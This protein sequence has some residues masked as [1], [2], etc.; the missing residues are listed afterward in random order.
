ME[1]D[2][3]CDYFHIVFRPGQSPAFA[4]IHPAELIDNFVELPKILGVRVDLVGDRLNSFSDFRQWQWFIDE[5]LRRGQP[6]IK[7]E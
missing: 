4:D 2:E 7:D 5:L 1:I 3:T 6:L